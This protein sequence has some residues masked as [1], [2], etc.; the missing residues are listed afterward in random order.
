MATYAITAAST[1]HHASAY[2]TAVLV[3]ILCCISIAVAAPAVTVT[4]YNSVAAI[5]V[6]CVCS[7]LV[8][9]GFTSC[10][11]DTVGRNYSLVIGA[12]WNNLCLGWVG[13][14]LGAPELSSRDADQSRRA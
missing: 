14:V 1:A 11:V 9:V 4:A 2:A 3:L 10:S 5:A 8:A 6:A 12:G 7:V 13:C